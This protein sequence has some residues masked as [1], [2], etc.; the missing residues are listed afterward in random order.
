MQSLLITKASTDGLTVK[1]IGKATAYPLQL[2]VGGVVYDRQ[3]LDVS[4]EELY[5]WEAN[6]CGAQ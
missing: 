5:Y 6:R 3:D 2:T 4:V 1:L